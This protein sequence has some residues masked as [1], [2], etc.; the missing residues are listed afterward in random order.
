MLLTVFSGVAAFSKILHC[1]ILVMNSIFLITYTRQKR[2]G[3]KNTNT[4][5]QNPHY[6]IIYLSS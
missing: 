1:L 6:A 3:T 5:Q 2:I 4:R